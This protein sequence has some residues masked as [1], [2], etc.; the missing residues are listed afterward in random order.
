MPLLHL[1]RN[2]VDH[3]VET[4]GKIEITLETEPDGWR[5]KVSDDGRG[6]DAESIKAK[7]KEKN[8]LDGSGNLTDI[9][10]IELI[11]LPEFS[12]K[13]S[14]TEIS[15]RGFGLDAVKSSV[16]K[17]GG[18]IKVESKRG[19]GATFEIFLPQ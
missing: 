1:V 10:L 17:T 6:I 2:A 11:F 15:G 18:T 4:R 3:A 14:L 12:T 5:L 7:A 8:L 19:K 16:E 9:E 13:T